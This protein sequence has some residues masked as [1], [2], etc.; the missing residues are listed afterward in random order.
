VGL[1]VTRQGLFV[2]EGRSALGA[3]V[4]GATGRVEVLVYRQMVFARKTLEA[5][6]ANVAVIRL[7]LVSAL[8]SFEAVRPF[9]SLAAIRTHV[10]AIGVVRVHVGRQMFLESSRVVAQ[11]TFQDHVA[12]PFRLLLS[13]L[14]LF[15][16]AISRNLWLLLLRM[17]EN[18]VQILLRRQSVIVL[19]ALLLLLLLLLQSLCEL[20]NGFDFGERGTRIVGIESVRIVVAA[21]AVA[22]FE[23][24][25]CGGIRR[26]SLLRVKFLGDFAVERLV[27]A[28]GKLHGRIRRHP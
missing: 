13:Q 27:A 11:L 10:V 5:I 15:H 2:F 17:V 9:E 24:V 12:C 14:F 19:A 22:V 28:V 18:Q 16:H 25:A 21:V 20:L 23:I 6:V 3:R 26:N 7:Q 4:G 8:V 1:Q